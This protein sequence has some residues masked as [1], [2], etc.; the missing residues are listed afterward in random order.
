[1]LLCWQQNVR[2]N[3]IILYGS[4]SCFLLDTDIYHKI[5]FSARGISWECSLYLIHEGFLTIFWLINWSFLKTMLSVAQGDLIVPLQFWF[6]F[7]FSLRILK[8]R[9]TRRTIVTFNSDEFNSVD[10]MRRLCDVWNGLNSSEELNSSETFYPSGP[11]GYNVWNACLF[12]T[13]S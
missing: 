4:T 10:L 2:L 7:R 9:F 11:D 13:T 8:G 12:R 1:M 6:N 3:F 5:T